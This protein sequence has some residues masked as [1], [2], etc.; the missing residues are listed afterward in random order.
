M[1]AAALASN[2]SFIYSPL[3]ARSSFA[4]GKFLG[5]N[6][7]GAGYQSTRTPLLVPTMNLLIVP[8]SFGYRTKD[9]AR[10]GETVEERE[11]ESY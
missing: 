6:W 10:S 11:S 1:G 2:E 8:G 9:D 7:Y 3:E 4:S 5:G